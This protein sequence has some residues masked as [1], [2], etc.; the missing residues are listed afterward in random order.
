MLIRALFLRTASFVDCSCS[1]PGVRARARGYVCE[2]V[3][4]CVQ[5]HVRMCVYQTLLCLKNTLEGCSPAAARPPHA[6]METAPEGVRT[7]AGGVQYRTQERA[8]RAPHG[9]AHTQPWA[10]QRGGRSGTASC[11]LLAGGGSQIETSRPPS[12]SRRWPRCRAL[13]PRAPGGRAAPADAP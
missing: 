3:R 4:V 11:R 6:Q 7:L 5:V 2:C 10:R 1:I 13:K 9:S 12:R 8:T